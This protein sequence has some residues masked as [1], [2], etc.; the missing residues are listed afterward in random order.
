VG[1]ESSDRILQHAHNTK[2]TS[3]DVPWVP[4][5][6]ERRHSR[7][8]CRPSGQRLKQG[9]TWGGTYMNEC[10]MRRHIQTHTHTHTHARAQTYSPTN[11]A[12]QWIQLA[13]ALV[14]QRISRTNLQ[15]NRFLCTRTNTQQTHQHTSDP[16]TSGED[17]TSAR[18]KLNVM[19]LGH[20]NGK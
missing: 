8:L 1:P 13:P 18:S 15:R 4:M 11:D 3:A 14:L 2:R 17:I 16:M 19:A 12:R 5:S 9:G 7:T 10:A 20:Q 6:G